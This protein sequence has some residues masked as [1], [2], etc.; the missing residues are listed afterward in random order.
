M[1]FGLIPGSQQKKALK[2]NAGLQLVQRRRRWT[3][4]KPTLIQCFVSAG[5]NTV[6]P[7][8]KLTSI[9]TSL[10]SYSMFFHSTYWKTWRKS[11]TWTQTFCFCH[12]WKISGHSTMSLTPHTS[13]HC[14]RSMRSPGWG[15]TTGLQGI[16]I[17][18]L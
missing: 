3:N 4:I 8:Q 17:T 11:C 16:L 2:V 14:P 7:A 10:I 13:Q 1:L 12:R 5:I 15:G 18:V 9:G 6:W